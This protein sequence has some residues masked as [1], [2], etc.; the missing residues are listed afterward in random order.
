MRIEESSRPNHASHLC[1]HTKRPDRYCGITT[2]ADV[3]T[4]T[5]P[6]CIMR[7]DDCTADTYIGS[8]RMHQTT[9]KHTC[10]GKAAELVVVSHGKKKNENW[11]NAITGT[12]WFH[13]L[14]C[15]QHTWHPV[16]T[17]N[18]EAA[19]IRRVPSKL[20]ERCG[21]QQTIAMARR[22]SGETTGHVS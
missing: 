9:R 14:G 21:K 4:N 6:Y 17:T 16:M 2:P 12:T 18:P 13:S 3:C 7:P 1:P 5:S 19:D 22:L 10:R 11:L 8:C 15:H 20:L